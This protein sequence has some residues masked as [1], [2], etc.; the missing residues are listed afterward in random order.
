MTVL[1]RLREWR[2]LGCAPAVG[3]QLTVI[4]EASRLGSLLEA[5]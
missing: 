5:K 1:A 4:S 3:Q 2:L